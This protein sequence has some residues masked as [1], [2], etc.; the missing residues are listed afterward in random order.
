MKNEQLPAMTPREEFAEALRSVGCI[1]EGEHPLMDGAAHRIRTEGDRA[2]ASSGFYVAYMDGRPAGYVKNNRTGEEVRWKTQGAFI[3]QQDKAAFQGECAR[4]QQERAKELLA[5]AG[6]PDGRNAQTG[7]PLVLFFDYQNAAQGS[8]AY[9][10]WY[11]RQFKKL[12]IQLEIRATDYNRFQEKMSKGAAQIFFWGWNADYPDAE[13]FLFLFYGPNG[14]VAHEGENAANYENPA[15]DQAFREM[16]LLEDGPQKAALI[17]RM[18]EILQQDAPILFGYFPPAA[19]A[20][21]SWVENA[22]PSGLVQ[23]ALQYYDVDADLRLAKIRE[24]NRPVL[25]PLAVLALG[26][27]LLVWGA[28]AVLARRQARRLRPLKSNGRSR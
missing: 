16:R 5:K 14:K 28:L 19:A 6:W 24:W 3:S 11:Q 25:W 15:F 7:E 27:G 22:K 9:L 17:D 10:E 2:G 1:V 21:Q 23:N 26:I 8:S 13:N 18:V 4:K 20:Y 12:G